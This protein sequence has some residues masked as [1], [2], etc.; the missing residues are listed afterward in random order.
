MTFHRLPIIHPL[1]T[2]TMTTDDGQTDDTSCHRRRT[3][4]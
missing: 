1:Q 2:T 3:T 4:A